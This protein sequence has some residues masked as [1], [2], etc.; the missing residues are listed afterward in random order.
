MNDSNDCPTCPDGKNDAFMDMTQA[1]PAGNGVYVMPYEPPTQA[2]LAELA[3]LTG[4]V[5][6]AGAHSASR[7]EGMPSARTPAPV[8]GVSP[9][10]PVVGETPPTN[11]DRMSAPHPGLEYTPNG[12]LIQ[13]EVNYPP[14]QPIQDPQDPTVQYLPQIT[15]APWGRPLTHLTTDDEDDVENDGDSKKLKKVPDGRIPDIIEGLWVPIDKRDNFKGELVR[16]PSPEEPPLSCCTR[17]YF[18]IRHTNFRIDKR[19]AMY[20]PYRSEPSAP[21]QQRIE[22]RGIDSL[23]D[24][25][26]YDAFINVVRRQIEADVRFPW[27]NFDKLKIE[28]EDR[29][30]RR[31]PKNC[32]PPQVEV[33]TWNGL[34]EVS[35]PTDHRILGQLPGT[36][37][38]AVRVQEGPV[39]VGSAQRGWY[40]IVE[41]FWVVEVLWNAGVSVHC[42]E[43]LR[44]GEF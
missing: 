26:G 22:R 19:V 14:P 30:R 20:G 43:P 33:E 44:T 21:R 2:E 8:E 28:A 27:R 18:W 36:V 29:A 11:A 31:C 32:Q 34:A 5:G 25:E 13:K 42:P 35:K 4:E 41:V 39:Q 40:V 16:F 23:T 38:H 3:R 7:A 17:Y 37:D 1:K 10:A 9:V 12:L 15:H 6:S 24:G